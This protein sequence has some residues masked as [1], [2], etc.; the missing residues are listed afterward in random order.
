MIFVYLITL[1]NTNYETAFLLSTAAIGI[2]L[3]NERKNIAGK[4]SGASL[5]IL[6]IVLLNFF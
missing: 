3:L 1:A 6:G 4:L 2:L 5:C